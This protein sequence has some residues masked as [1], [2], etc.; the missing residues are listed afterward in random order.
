MFVASFAVRLPNTPP[1]PTV[2]VP[3]PPVIETAPPPKDA[4][5]LAAVTVT[6]PGIGA[7]VKSPDSD[8]PRK[9]IWPPV[10]PADSN[11]AL[12]VPLATSTV[13]GDPLLPGIGR[14]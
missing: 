2:S 11:G 7:N 4:V 6:P 9:P 13:T 12:A 1:A 3:A 10:T 5:T 8:W 14:A